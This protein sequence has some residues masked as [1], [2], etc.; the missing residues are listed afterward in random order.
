VDE[1]MMDTR[2]RW[3]KKIRPMRKER[4]DN[5]DCL[6]DTERK[7]MRNG[8]SENLIPKHHKQSQTKTKSVNSSHA[9]WKNLCTPFILLQLGEKPVLLTSPLQM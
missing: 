3:R 1:W 6:K 8:T 7:G 4:E 5:E 2:E 9:S